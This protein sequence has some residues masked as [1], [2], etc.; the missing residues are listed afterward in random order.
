MYARQFRPVVE[1]QENLGKIIVMNIETGEHEIADDA[2]TASRRALTKHP[3][4]A[5]YAVRIGY[6]SVYAFDGL[7]PQPVKQ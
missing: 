4:A 7:G 2:L 6:D 5:I 1:T 3:G